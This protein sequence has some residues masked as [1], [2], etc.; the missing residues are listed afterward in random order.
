MCTT[1]LPRNDSEANQA[2]DTMVAYTCDDCFTSTKANRHQQEF[3]CMHALS[4]NVEML[5]SDQWSFTLHH[6]AIATQITV[7]LPHLSSH[8]KH[9]MGNYMRCC[10]NY[11]DA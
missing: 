6:I 4:S 1:A 2:R 10:K 11:K 8:I 3:Q 9:T 7:S 5:S